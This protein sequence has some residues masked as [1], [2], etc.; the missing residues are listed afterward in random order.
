MQKLIKR[1]L[2]TYEE[3]RLSDNFDLY[4]NVLKVL[5]YLVSVFVEEETKGSGDNKDIGN[6]R[7][8]NG[9]IKGK[10]N[11][12]ESVNFLS[13]INKINILLDWELNYLWVKTKKIEAEFVRCLF[14]IGFNLL[15]N[16]KSL[17]NNVDLKEEIFIFLQKIISKYGKEVAGSM[18]QITARITSVLYKIDE[19]ADPIADFVVSY[20]ESDSDSTFAVKIIEELTTTLFN[21][22]SSHESTGIKNWSIFLSKLSQKIPNVMFSSLGKLLGMLDWEAYQL[23][24]SF[25]NIVT[26]FI[27]NVLTKNIQESEDAEMRSN[28]Q[29]TKDKLLRIL[30]RR[31][32]DKT[33]Y[34]RKEVLNCFRLLIP[35]NVIESYFYE[36]LMEIALSRIKDWTINVRKAAMGLLE[37]IVKTKATFY[38]VNEKKGDGFMSKK[39]IDEEI[40]NFDKLIADNAKWID[41][42]KNEIKNLKVIYT[43]EHPEINKEEIN[44]GLKNDP[45]FIELKEKYDKIQKVKTDQEDFREF[46]L[47]Y[48]TL[49]VSLENSVP[50][51]TQ[52]LGSKNQADII[53]SVKLLTYLQKMKIERA[54]EGTKKILVLFFNK[55]EAVKMEA[56]EAYK[57]LYLTDDMGLDTRA[58]ALIELLKD[59][60]ASE[61]AWVEEFLS[62]AVKHKVMSGD[63][64]KALW[65]IFKMCNNT[66]IEK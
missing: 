39:T 24:I 18:T 1:P 20:T 38:E 54:V 36:D 12:E 4:R 9:K 21:T 56:L 59:A 27:S 16:S 6:L 28:Y 13:T 61:E 22:D 49:I 47:G 5:I 11:K 17:K 37:E 3:N 65:R 34:V 23:R 62:L 44:E 52:L 46:Y 15:E 31:I 42:I 66:P 33:S 2:E 40:A 51:L 41:D 57:S 53:E 14:D 25:V 45:R 43:D 58:F 35:K 29:K 30:L 19:I 55:E 60:D 26:N 8:K 63:I 64:Y 50:L 32:Y 48:K 7:A 10:R